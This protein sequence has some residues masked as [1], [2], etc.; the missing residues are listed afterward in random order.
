LFNLGWLQAKLS[1]EA[2]QDVQATLAELTAQSVASDLL[3]QAP[4]T[5]RLL[6]C[7]GGARNTHVMARLAALLPQIGVGTTGEIG[8]PVDQVEAAAFAWLAHRYVERLPGNLPAV[9]GA[10]QACVLGALYPA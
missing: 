6:A 8:L 4:A 1:D 10:R 2:P 9:T 3:A 7:G 5:Q